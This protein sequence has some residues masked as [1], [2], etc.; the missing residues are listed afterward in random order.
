MGAVKKITVATF[1]EI[2]NGRGD[3]V[4]EMAYDAQGITDDPE[5]AEAGKAAIKAEDE[6]LR[7]CNERQIE[8]G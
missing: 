7:L 8:R 2:Y 3:S 5:L 4:M 6:F 1:K